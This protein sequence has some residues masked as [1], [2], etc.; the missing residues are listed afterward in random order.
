M[1]AASTIAQFNGS[2]TFKTV[3]TLL[4][5]ALRQ[6]DIGGELADTSNLRQHLP[7]R[8]LGSFRANVSRRAPRLRSP[9]NK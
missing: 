5:R 9:M 3:V 8:S 1:G 6:N 2:V 4:L 7:K